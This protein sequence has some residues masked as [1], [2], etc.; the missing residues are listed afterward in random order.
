MAAVMMNR[1]LKQIWEKLGSIHLT[2]VLCL[3]LTADL[4]W[5]YLCLNRHVTLFA[6]LNDIGLTAWLDTYGRHNL[7]HTAWFFILMGLLA[8]LCINTFVCTTERVV[9]MVRQRKRFGP[10]RLLFKL[11]P[12]VMHYA[13]IVILVGYLCS[14]LFSS[15]LDTCTLVPGKSMVLPGSAA[16][17][18][19][20]AFHPIHYQGERLPAF[21]NR[22]LH[23][24]VDLTLTDGTRKHSR[25]LSFNRPVRFKGYHIVLKSFS[26]KKKGGGMSKRVRVNLSIRKDPGVGFYLAGVALFTLGL[27]I[28][29]FDWIVPKTNVTE[30]ISAE[31]LWVRPNSHEERN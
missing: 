31:T 16:K 30:N 18:T 10:Q 24:N 1:C 15:V 29:V 12:H 27:L 5:G 4:A 7:S 14:Y 22:V 17:I 25:V 3:M 26:P 28:Y 11:A 23:P 2:V 19:F 21:K 6:P 9:W 13:M 20:S 8:L